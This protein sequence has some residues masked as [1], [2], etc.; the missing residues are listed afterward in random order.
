MRPG[1][2]VA[3][4]RAMTLALAGSVTLFS[5]PAWSILPPRTTTTQP[6]SARADT[7]SNRFS[8]VGGGLEG[9]KLQKSNVFDGL[10]SRRTQNVVPRLHCFPWHLLFYCPFVSRRSWCTQQ[11]GRH[12]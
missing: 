10:A 12:V 1:S 4:G 7:P 11:G 5:G 2:N 8:T 3:S 9:Q 6:V